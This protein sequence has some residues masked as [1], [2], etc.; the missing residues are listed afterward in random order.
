A[1]AAVWLGGLVALTRIASVVEPAR[2][3]VLVR[4]YSG[5][6]LPAAVAVAL[7]GL[8]SGGMRLNG[9]AELLSTGYGRL[10]LLKFAALALLLAFGAW[11]RLRLISSLEKRPAANAVFYFRVVVAELA[12]M[13]VAFGLAAALGRTAPPVPIAA[14]RDLGGSITPAEYLTG[15]P[16]PP[17]LHLGAVFTVWKFDLLWSLVSAAGVL[18]YLL[19]VARLRR[20]GD[21]WPLG[22]TASW[23]SG[24]LLLG[25]TTNGFLNAY[26][27]YLF[28][29]HMLGHM[30]LTMLIPLLLVLGAPV[31][32]IMRAV[33]K[34]D[35]GS[36]GVREWVLWLV[37]TPYSRVVTNAVFAAIVFAVS[38][39]AF[40][41]TPMLRWAMEE[42]I[43]HQWMIV[44]FLLSGYFFALVLIGVD[45]VPHRPA[46]PVRIIVL[47]AT[48]GAHAFFGV[49]IMG[50]ES[51]LAADWFGA[52]G[53]VWGDPP[54]LD[55]NN[56]GG[57][58]WGI[59][60]LP[61]LMRVII[62]SVQ[63]ARADDK[64]QRRRDRA[65]DRSDDAE[66][67]AYNEMLQDYS[68]SGRASAEFS[69]RQYGV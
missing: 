68:R 24:M 10:L 54:L 1:G 57:I 12:I 7:S 45:P 67:R 14:A 35:D 46:F 33:P 56:G 2:L 60:E 5:F 39:W 55:Q 63:W 40:Y 4:R 15:D 29:I 66:L 38:L 22:R 51:L 9:P 69:D 50:S 25:Y 31:T 21:K 61:T 48:M 19:G 62:V 23:V 17:E 36:W 53:R 49:T 27:A 20:R 34:R 3:P 52:M 28:S 18:F 37:E 42:H 6:A 16:L 30:L 59:G 58:A 32:L 64:E 8:V 13:G 47:L 26:E 43:G 44:H 41:Y 65:E 11:H